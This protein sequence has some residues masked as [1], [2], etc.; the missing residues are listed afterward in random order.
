MGF[1][2]KPNYSQ[3]RENNSPWTLKAGE[4]GTAGHN[5]Y[6]LLPAYG[7]LAASQKHFLYIPLHFGYKGV[8]FNKPDS[9]NPKDLPQRPFRCIQE[10]DW[11]SGIIRTSCPQCE[12]H[13]EVEL[14]V[15]RTKDELT[16]QFKEEGKSDE[17]AKKLIA[18]VLE[19]HMNWLRQYNLDSKYYFAAMNEDGEFN[20]LKVPSKAKKALEERM[21][22]VIEQ[23][24]VDPLDVDQG[25]WFDFI[26]TGEGFTDTSY[27]VDVVY[28]TVVDQQTG[29]RLK[30]LK[31][32]PM[33]AEQVEKAQ[34][35]LPELVDI[36]RILTAEQ[37]QRLVDCG[38]DPHEVDSIMGIVQRQGTAD[39]RARAAAGIPAEEPTPLQPVKP[40][41]QQQP[42][43]A[44]KPVTPLSVE[45][46]D[47][48]RE[49]LEFQ[50][51]KRRQR[52][53]EAKVFAQAPAPEVAVAPDEEPVA[54]GAP[55]TP[56]G[57]VTKTKT[58]SS[59]PASMDD[60]LGS[61]GF[62]PGAAT[63]SNTQKS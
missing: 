43:P 15:K 23:E 61:F 25:V 32:A 10:K 22:E 54:A 51:M 49:F 7:K 50:A 21:K 24:G 2:A 35:V 18:E 52:E 3:R 48:R 20:V 63:P 59:Q 36:P 53:A 29:K 1:F 56:S 33:T 6:R 55:M 31:M 34:K 46:T 47:E 9:T 44:M 16:K 12:K 42:S 13:A 28:E 39:A 4:H 45:E 30:S 17:E 62:K 11:K 37:I 40:Q 38:N 27:S 58:L 60:F 19:P 57:A 26:R 14:V 5:R 8:S 41:H